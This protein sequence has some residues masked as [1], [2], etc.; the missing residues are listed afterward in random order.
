MHHWFGTII[1]N[2]TPENAYKW[3]SEGFNDYFAHVAMEEGGLFGPSEFKDRINYIIKLYQSDSTN[4]WPNEKL[5]KDYWAS[6]KIN[7]LPYQRGLIFALYL[8]EAIKKQTSGKLALKNVI[9]Q[10]LAE[11]RLQK[12]GFS[13]PWFLSVLRKITGQD[14]REQIEE[15]ITKG[16]FI[17]INEWQKVS[18]KMA[19]VQSEVFDLGFTI[20]KSAMSLNAKIT[21]IQEGSN[22]QKAGLQ[23]DDVIAGFSSS[24]KPNEIT[25]VTV[26]RG[27]E[28]IRF[29]YLPSRK[30]W[31]PQLQ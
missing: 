18:T 27:E 16:T 15:Y 1:K 5:E 25:T 30:I 22:V 31:T 9:L 17:P 13:L 4:Q 29:Q 12:K 20:D 7:I 24:L 14:Y 26:K 19:L 8:D 28:K 3:F 10:L 11:A 23:I 6:S 2:G 21:S